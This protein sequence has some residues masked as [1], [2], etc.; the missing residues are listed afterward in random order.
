MRKAHIDGAI[1]IALRPSL[2]RCV[3]MMSHYLPTPGHSGQRR[4]HETLRQTFAAT[5][6]SL[7]STVLYEIALAVPGMSRSL[8]ADKRCNYFLPANSTSFSQ[9]ISSDRCQKQIRKIN[10]FSLLQIT[11]PILRELYQHRGR[12]ARILQ[13]T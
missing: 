2:C 4:M 10:S 3:L 7:T 9:R 11:I 5:V 8:V 1:Q 6:W 13:T 12:Q